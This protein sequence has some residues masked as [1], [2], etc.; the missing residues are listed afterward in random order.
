MLQAKRTKIKAV[1]RLL[2]LFYVTE[3]THIS[4]CEAEKS[5]VFSIPANTNT[6]FSNSA[7]NL[8]P[9]EDNLADLLALTNSVGI[10]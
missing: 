8:T 7:D 9:S 5:K 2:Q 4:K 10:E 1:D 3:G 6:V